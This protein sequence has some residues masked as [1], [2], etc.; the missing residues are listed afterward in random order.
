VFIIPAAQE[1]K[2]GK[3]LK[4]DANLSNLGRPCVKNKT[5]KKEYGC[6][7]GRA[8]AQCHKVLSS[9]PSTTIKKKKKIKI[10]KPIL[11]PPELPNVI[12]NN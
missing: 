10:Y 2:T 6:T 12:Q 5:I 1:A 4:F 8:T 7:S 3:S 9:I 11:G